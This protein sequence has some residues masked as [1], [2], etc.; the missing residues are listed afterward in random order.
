MQEGLRLSSGKYHSDDEDTYSLDCDDNQGEPIEEIEYDSQD[1]QGSN[2]HNFSELRAIRMLCM[3]YGANEPDTLFAARS[4]IEDEVYPIP[5]VFKLT[6]QLTQVN[7]ACETHDKKY[8][9]GVFPLTY[10]AV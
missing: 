8:E 9:T 5:K 7:Q 1:L 6:R 4:V 3:N 10:I 2:H